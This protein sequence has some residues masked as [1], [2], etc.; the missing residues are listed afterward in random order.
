MKKTRF[1]SLLLAVLLLATAIPFAASAADATGNVDATDFALTV[2]DSRLNAYVLNSQYYVESSFDPAT[3]TS[4]KQLIWSAASASNHGIGYETRDAAATAALFSQ[5]FTMSVTFYRDGN[6]PGPISRANLLRLES[7]STKIKVMLGY[8]DLFFGDGTSLYKAADSTSSVQVSKY[9]WHTLGLWIDPTK[10][11]N[12][13]KVYL[14]G[15]QLLIGS[16]RAETSSADFSGAGSTALLTMMHSLVSSNTINVIRINGFS[17]KS[18]DVTAEGA[19]NVSMDLSPVSSTVEFQNYGEKY[20]LFDGDDTALE[21]Y[22]IGVWHLEDWR[23]T[24][25]QYGSGSYTIYEEKIPVKLTI[26]SMSKDTDAETPTALYVINVAD[27]DADELSNAKNTELILELLKMGFIVV[28]AD[29]MD[30][31]DTTGEDFNWCIQAIRIALSNTNYL[32]LAHHNADIYCVPEGYLVAR[33]LMYFNFEDNARKGTEEYIVDVFNG[34]ASGSNGG[35]FR[36]TK[37]SPS[38]WMRPPRTDT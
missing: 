25:S 23:L 30:N 7:G 32:F 38:P 9:E 13:V 4:S 22:A 14:D 20:S 1:L 6:N 34:T 27:P 24:N 35:G 37:L 36:T 3:Y 33:N 10:N 16:D 26:L 21:P 15:T 28:V 5:P 11:E 29:F 18:D 8:S 2:S 19:Y 31:P 17:I 12:N